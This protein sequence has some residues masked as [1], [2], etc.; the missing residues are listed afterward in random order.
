MLNCEAEA[1]PIFTLD[2]EQRVT[3]QAYN[4]ILFT[5][6]T[7]VKALFQ[8]YILQRDIIL[9]FKI[10]GNFGNNQKFRSTSS[11]GKFVKAVSLLE[12]FQSAFR[13]HHSTE[14][15]LVRVTIF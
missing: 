9:S 13:V 1:L 14:T 10:L 5:A 11:G 8:Q 4:G 15:T 2:C 6:G 7:R 12:D 3:Y